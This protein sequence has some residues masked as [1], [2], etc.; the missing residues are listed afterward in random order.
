MQGRAC[1]LA[2][3][4]GGGGGSPSP[5][6]ALARPAL[7]IWPFRGR[8]PGDRVPTTLQR[9]HTGC[10]QAAGGRRRHGALTVSGFDDQHHHTE[11]PCFLP[12]P[13]SVRDLRDR[14][15]AQTPRAGCPGGQA[16]AG[17][18]GLRK[19]GPLRE[20]GRPGSSGP[21]ADAICTPPPPR[22]RSAGRARRPTLL[23]CS[24]CWNCCLCFSRNCWCCC[25]MTRCCRAGAFWGSGADCVRPS[26]R[27]CRSLCTDGD[28]R[29]APTSACACRG[30]APRPERHRRKVTWGPP[31]LH[32]EARGAGRREPPAWASVSRGRRAQAFRVTGSGAAGPPG[33]GPTTPRP[34]PGPRTRLRSE[35]H[36]GAAGVACATLTRAAEVPVARHVLEDRGDG[37]SPNR[38]RNQVV[39][40][41][42]RPEGSNPLKVSSSGDFIHKG[43]VNTCHNP[44]ACGQNLLQISAKVLPPPMPTSC[45]P[46]TCTWTECSRIWMDM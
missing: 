43:G 42:T 36:R 28:T 23:M 9:G 17:A 30:S 12:K 25:W 44:G 7:G 33:S 27:C 21:H 24:C 6:G 14:A 19:A 1:W 41:K 22:M 29:S 35:R 46:C 37:S 20:E 45:F 38:P 3:R 34:G 4:A 18:E 32:P 2:L 16:R 15:R 31:V 40:E 10:I 13:P 8:V 5:T 26:G 11:L 39:R